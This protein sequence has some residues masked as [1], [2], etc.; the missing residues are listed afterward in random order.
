MFGGLGYMP[1][2]TSLPAAG[3]GLPASHETRQRLAD[4]DRLTPRKDWLDPDRDAVPYDH[5]A[6]RSRTRRPTPEVRELLLK[7]ASEVFG[8]RGYSEA[9]LDEI[10]AEAGVA[11]SVIFRQFGTK[12]SLFRAAQVQPFIDL[13]TRFRQNVAAEADDLWDEQRLF[14]STAGVIYDSFRAHRST[15]LA[16]AAMN[17]LDPEAGRETRAAIDRVFEDIMKVAVKE[18]ERRGWPPQKDLELSIRMTTGMVASVALFDDLFVP[19]GRRRPS[20]QQL[21][22]HLT[23]IS[24]HGMQVDETDGD[25][26]RDA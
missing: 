21:I 25:G 26:R 19:A 3:A 6:E 22:D 18:I 14:S 10:A 5:M 2:P 15:I 12:S 13:L 24:L 1:A 11:R 16:V 23:A 9:T 20:R 8:R 4:V 7:A 17:A